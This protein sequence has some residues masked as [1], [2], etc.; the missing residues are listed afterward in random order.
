MQ[1]S[2]VTDALQR[3]ISRQRKGRLVCPPRQGTAIFGWKGTAMASLHRK[4]LAREAMNKLATS[5]PAP[6][7]EVR[8]AEEKTEKKQR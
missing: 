6:E 1:A 4:R 3:E 8:V 2:A 5:I 7:G